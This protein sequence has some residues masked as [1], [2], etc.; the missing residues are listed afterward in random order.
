MGPKLVVSSNAPG[1]VEQRLPEHL[2]A[3]CEAH[4]I[5]LFDQA[6]TGMVKLDIW[7]DHLEA[8]AWLT[9]ESVSIVP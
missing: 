1:I 3:I 4:D 8:K 7:P 6:Q 2:S 9:G 5:H